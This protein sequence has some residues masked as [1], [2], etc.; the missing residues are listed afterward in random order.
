M[1]LIEILL[2][3]IDFS[4]D[5]KEEKRNNFTNNLSINNSNNNSN[6]NNNNKGIMEFNSNNIDYNSTN[7]VMEH[8]LTD[9]LNSLNNYDTLITD[10][11][12]ITE[13]TAPFQERLQRLQNER[14]NMESM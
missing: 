12:D 10:M 7:K 14:S 3:N 2:K 1:F 11:Q 5:Q 9:N 8:D 6:N 4:L 13:D